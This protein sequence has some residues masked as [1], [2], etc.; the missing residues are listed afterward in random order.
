M[1][2]REPHAHAATAR[3][4]SLQSAGHPASVADD[5]FQSNGAAR[6]ARTGTAARRERFGFRISRFSR[7][8]AI[9]RALVR[10][11][12]AFLKSYQTRFRVALQSPALQFIHY[13]G[14]AGS[15]TEK[16]NNRNTGSRGP[17]AAPASTAPSFVPRP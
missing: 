12:F 15:K 4:G 10:L 1:L 6:G 16:H 13:T 17:A 8:C 11:L 14:D 7:P 2:E 5:G 3:H 9:K